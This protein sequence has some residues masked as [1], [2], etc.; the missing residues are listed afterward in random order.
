MSNIDYSGNPNQRTPCVLVLDASGSMTTPT[1]KGKTR[2][3]ELNEGIRIL[4]QELNADDTATVRV[5]LGV[6]IVG[7]PSN[8]AEILMDWTDAS[9]FQA[10]PLRSDGS[11]PLGKGAT[12]ALQMIE[13]GKQNLRSAGISYTRPW[14]MI[15]SD[16]E[17]T[18][19][20]DVWSDA[21]HQCRTAEAAKRVEIFAIGVEGANLAKLGELSTKPPLMLG[22]MKFKELFVWLSASLSAA[23]K[24][25]PG[26]TLQ[27][28]STDPWR[29]V[30]L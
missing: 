8:D 10:F 16:G 12:I 14:M 2:I 27:L 19:S 11:T 5:Q 1:A 17:P 24:S 3:D 29:N 28:P 26:D 7:G 20:S 4:Q 22:G 18:D 21:V 23:S 13:Q 9:N 15:I 25:R 6:V 30:G